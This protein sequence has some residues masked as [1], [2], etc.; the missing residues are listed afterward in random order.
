MELPLPVQTIL[1]QLQAEGHAAYAVGGCVR[2]ALRGCEPHDWD[3]CSSATPEEIHRCFSQLRTID[4]GAAHGTVTVLVDDTPYEIT[5]FRQDG[6]YADHRRPEQVKFVRTLEADLARRDFTINAMAAGLDGKI[7]DLY[8]G[9]ADLTQKIVRCVGDPSAR[10]QEDALRILR[11]LRFAAALDF[12]IE[13]VTAQAAREKKELLKFVSA[14]RIYAELNKLLVA[15]GAAR[16]LREYPDIFG[17]FLPEILPCVGFQQYSPYHDQDVWGHTVTAL[18]YAPAD[19]LV[20]WA[21]LLHDVGKPETFTLD[22]QG[23]GHFYEHRIAGQ[24]LADTI[25][26]RLKSDKDT[27]VRVSRL[28]LYHDA[29]LPTTQ[30]G[31]LRWIREFGA[32]DLQR[33]I[34]VRRCDGAAHAPHEKLQT[35]KIE[36]EGFA[37]KAAGLATAKFPFQVRDLDI[38]G[39]DLLELGIPQGK[40]VGL[41]LSGLLEAVMEGKC[42][43]RRQALLDYVSKLL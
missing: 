24:R 35:N 16:V 41:A 33:L 28:V 42:P 4:T 43:N 26:R 7:Q 11:A 3:I 19:R 29:P 38:S 40:Q 5:T 23:I 8:G 22:E 39:R 12:S 27:R 20:R 34:E 17:T 6:S 37:Q 15:P 14:E 25:F 21:I 30:K 10:F 1:R 13:P 2:D 36:L 9:R 18:S 32:E 31:I